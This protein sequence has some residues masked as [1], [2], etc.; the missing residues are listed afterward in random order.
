M[1]RRCDYLC[2][3]YLHGQL[4]PSGVIAMVLPSGQQPKGVLSQDERTS[5][6]GRV[7][8]AT[9]GPAGRHDASFRNRTFNS[10]I[11]SSP[12]LG[13]RFPVCFVKTDFMSESNLLFKAAAERS[14]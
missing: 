7:V 8:A 2:L 5:P 14:F 1:Q 9:V 6:V 4:V 12:S 13:N 10:M 11:T 3:R